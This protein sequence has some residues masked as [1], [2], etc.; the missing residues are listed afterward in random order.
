MIDPKP[1]GAPVDTERVIRELHDAFKSLKGVTAPTTFS[2]PGKNEQQHRP[3]QSQNDPAKA[4]ELLG[5][6]DPEVHHKNRFYRLEHEIY[7]WSDDKGSLLFSRPSA[8]ELIEGVRDDL[9]GARQHFEVYR[10][11]LRPEPTA[12]R[13]TR[14]KD[15]GNTEEGREPSASS[16]AAVEQAETDCETRLVRSQKPRR[17]SF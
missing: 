15:G 9:I 14:T 2:P 16:L 10:W 6:P 3:Q 4:L 7:E 1:A 11:S 8:Q 17:C 12:Y 5:I 13:S